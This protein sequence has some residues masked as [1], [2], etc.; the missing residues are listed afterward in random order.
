ML[1]LVFHIVGIRLK[2]KISRKIWK[3]GDYIWLFMAIFALIGGGYELRKAI[4]D[5]V[6]QSTNV[7]LIDTLKE[8]ELTA[9]LATDELINFVNQ[10]DLSKY[11]HSR[12]DQIAKKSV[13][14]D[15]NLTENFKL[16]SEAEQSLSKSLFERAMVYLYPF[17][18]AFALALRF[19]LASA[20]IFDW[21]AKPSSSNQT[22]NEPDPFT[23]LSVS[24]DDI[25]SEGTRPVS[26]KEYYSAQTVNESQVTPDSVKS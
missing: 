4:S 9:Q 5:D 25:P 26:D 1:L 18:L 3:S 11:D 20:D 10:K 8:R 6:I 14:L 17:V 13:V 24:T 23:A 22:S 19:T 12:L 2:G 21:Y 16:Q 15:K 7:A